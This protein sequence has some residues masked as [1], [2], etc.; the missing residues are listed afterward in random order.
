[1]QPVF[2]F[3]PSP[4]G[5]LHLGHAYSALLNERLA[6]T[7]K[8][9]LLLRI[10]DIDILRCKPEFEH[11]IYEDLGWLGLQW[12][13]PVLRQSERFD[14]YGKAFACLKDMGVVYPCFCS[15]KDIAQAVAD[16]MTEEVDPDGAPIYPGTCRG[17]S[18]AEV[19]SRINRGDEHA[20]R[21]DVEKALACIDEPLIYERFEPDQNNNAVKSISAF[22]CYSLRW[23]NPIIVRKET[24]TS[25]HLS[26]VVDDA[27]Q[28]VTQVV[29]GRDLE[30]ATDLHVLLQKLLGL[31]TPVYYHHELIRGGQGEK[32]SKSLFSE[33]LAELRAKENTP[34][35]IRRMLGFY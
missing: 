16:H 15:R 33:S 17:L 8:G 1:M 35:D 32:L 34:E 9:R 22:E 11:A 7:C 13:K 3:A 5:L 2:R 31:P 30:P 14:A 25:Y 18:L 20:W 27:Q 21:L 24:P 12:E 29:R 10:E 19:H 26:V 28:G 23:G 4:N 6:R